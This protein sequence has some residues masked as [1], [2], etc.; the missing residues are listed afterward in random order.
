[1]LHCLASWDII[2]ANKGSAALPLDAG[3]GS[4]GIGSSVV[5]H[6]IR[7]RMINGKDNWVDSI[8][9]NSSKLFQEVDYRWVLSGGACGRF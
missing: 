9:S 4:W 7:F 5:L 8:G 1:M 6:V 3:S 2:T